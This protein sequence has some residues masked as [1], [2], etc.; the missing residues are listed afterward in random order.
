MLVWDPL[1]KGMLMSRTSRSNVKR[2]SAIQVS[3]PIIASRR[4]GALVTAT[5][6]AA[7][8]MWSSWMFEKWTVM[9]AV[10]A[11][12]AMAAV[13]SMFTPWRLGRVTSNHQ[14]S[15]VLGKALAPIAKQITRNRKRKSARAY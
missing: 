14:G 1:C 13:A 12:I 3:A 4:L 15:D 2:L 10:S 9:N 11:N 8:Q 6:M 7:A 5:P